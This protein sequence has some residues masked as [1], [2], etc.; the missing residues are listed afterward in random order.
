MTRI[1]GRRLAA[2]FFYLQAGSDRAKAF[3]MAHALPRHPLLHCSHSCPL[4]DLIRVQACSSAAANGRA[5]EPGMTHAQC[6]NAIL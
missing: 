3:S 2:R 6:R 1:F 4:S 5:D